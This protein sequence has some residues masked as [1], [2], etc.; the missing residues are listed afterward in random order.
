[1]RA[2]N[3]T[4][5]EVLAFITK[6]PAVPTGLT[7]ADMAAANDWID[8]AMEQWEKTLVIHDIRDEIQEFTRAAATG[9]DS[10]TAR[11]LSGRVHDIPK[12]V[13]GVLKSFISSFMTKI[14]KLSTLLLQDAERKRETIHQIRIR[15]S[16]NTEWIQYTDPNSKTLPAQSM[17]K[18]LMNASTFDVESNEIDTRVQNLKPESNQSKEIANIPTIIQ[19][20][21][22]YVQD[23]IQVEA[24][25]A[26]AEKIRRVG[27]HTRDFQEARGTN[28]TI[29]QCKKD[30]DD[31]EK[32]IKLER[33]E[34]SKQMPLFVKLR[35][36]WAV[37]LGK[38]P[39]PAAAAGGKAAVTG[40]PA[41]GKAAGP[42]PTA[43]GTGPGAAA[44]GKAAAGTGPPA[45]GGK[46]PVTPTP[47]AWSKPL[48]IPAA[49]GP[50]PH[51]APAAAGAGPHPAPFNQES[52][53]VTIELLTL[54]AQGIPTEFDAC[55]ANIK[56]IEA[57]MDAL[58]HIILDDPRRT[59]LP[60]TLGKIHIEYGVTV[61]E[62]VNHERQLVSKLHPLQARA[63]ATG[64]ATLVTLATEIGN[65]IKINARQ[66]TNKSES[67]LLY[68]EHLQQQLKT[69][70]AAS[71]QMKASGNEVTVLTAL[72]GAMV[73]WAEKKSTEIVK[74]QAE[75]AKANSLSFI[76]PLL[77]ETEDQYT[78]RVGA[79]IAAAPMPTIAPTTS[80]PSLTDNY[81]HALFRYINM[82]AAPPSTSGSATSKT[83]K[84]GSATSKTS[85]AGSA[86]GTGSK[87]AG[88]KHSKTAIDDDESD[89]EEEEE[90]DKDNTILLL[91]T[92]IEKLTDW[93]IKLQEAAR[94]MYPTYAREKRFFGDTWKIAGGPVTKLP[95]VLKTKIVHAPAAAEGYELVD[96]DGTRERAMPAW[97]SRSSESGSSVWARE[98][99]GIPVRSKEEIEQVLFEH[100]LRPP[101]G[102]TGER[103]MR[104]DPRTDSD[105]RNMWMHDPND[106]RRLLDVDNGYT[107]RPHG[108]STLYDDIQAEESRGSAEYLRPSGRES[109][110]QFIA[111]PID[112]DQ[113]IGTY[114]FEPTDD[115]RTRDITTEILRVLAK[116][117]NET[118][119]ESEH[120]R[121][122]HTAHVLKQMSATI[123]GLM[124]SLMRYQQ[125]EATEIRK[126]VFKNELAQIMLKPT[127][128]NDEKVHRALTNMH[129][130]LIQSID[131]QD[132]KDCIPLVETFLQLAKNTREVFIR[133]MQSPVSQTKISFKG[134]EF[135]GAGSGKY[136]QPTIDY[137]KRIK[138]EIKGR[139]K[140]SKTQHA[141]L[142]YQDAVWNLIQLLGTISVDNAATHLKLRQLNPG[143]ARDENIAEV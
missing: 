109:R 117:Y 49:T 130:G 90:E 43:A 25:V 102:G 129:D 85:K 40:P 76:F 54:G 18:R 82:S 95:T 3:K 46:T 26:A 17:L 92:H 112:W 105:K 73:D 128:D 35:D 32:Q 36:E 5:E 21:G 97:S 123:S 53:A 55:D 110:S 99:G 15:V 140:P 115:E 119:E 30:A 79:I 44:G 77:G 59:D 141:S 83:S 34:I 138:S 98:V 69:W 78:K 14:N 6:Q 111:G 23:T 80:G 31:Y 93:G 37:K 113:A 65:H 75:L 143:A 67:E 24:F 91:Q 63:S 106:D 125:G 86:K 41:G 48:V 136:N 56:K 58:R 13:G 96:E 64:D 2:D 11:E 52:I 89:E 45:S 71:K 9:P 116:T 114:Q 139:L 134:T 135:D 84:A 39:K 57:Q 131:T 10:T 87:G 38:A 74:L 88:S 132:N 127:D 107:L 51:P 103:N 142:R 100:G 19:T 104:Y 72:E 12:D 68:I 120:R 47:S 4:L 124:H 1:M 126:Q 66:R 29:K 28:I 42:A 122:V 94:S 8:R 108:R 33:E 101:R 27:D 137:L 70:D 61:L 50:G 20:I 7:L 60:T 81:L 16:K 62:C 121:F 118:N 22:L 133:Y